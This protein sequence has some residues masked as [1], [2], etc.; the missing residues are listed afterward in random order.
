MANRIANV[1]LWISIACSMVLFM[2]LIN[3]SGLLFAFTGA[4]SLLG[5][6]F[7]IKY[8]LGDRNVS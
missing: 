7:S 2:M 3:S 1:L 4:V 6:G 8:I 5:I